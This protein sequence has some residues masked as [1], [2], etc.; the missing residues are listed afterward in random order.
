MTSVWI[1]YIVYWLLFLLFFLLFVFSARCAL[2]FGKPNSNRLHTA[3][4]NG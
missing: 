1:L 4:G 3:F 2:G